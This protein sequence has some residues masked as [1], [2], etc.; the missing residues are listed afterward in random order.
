MDLTKGSLEKIKQKAEERISDWIESC[1]KA[2]ITRLQDQYGQTAF[3]RIEFRKSDVPTP[4]KARIPT[5]LK[6]L[7]LVE[8]EKEQIKG[9]RSPEAREKGTKKADALSVV[10]MKSRQGT[11]SRQTMD[12]RSD[13]FKKYRDSSSKY[14]PTVLREMNN[15]SAHN[16]S[17]F[18]SS[19]CS[20]DAIS[21]LCD[22]P[23]KYFYPARLDAY[24]PNSNEFLQKT[25]VNE[26]YPKAYKLSDRLKF[27][28][29][30]AVERVE[31]NFYNYKNSEKFKPATPKFT[32]KSGKIKKMKMPDGQVHITEEQQTCLEESRDTFCPEIF[33][34]Q[35]IP[36]IHMPRGS[37]K[38]A[39][40]SPSPSFIRI[41]SET[42][43][44]ISRPPSTLSQ[45]P[46]TFTIDARNA[47]RST[48]PLITFG[49][50]ENSRAKSSA[51]NERF[52]EVHSPTMLSVRPSRSEFQ[53]ATSDRIRDS[54]ALSL[55]RQKSK[56][57]RINLTTSPT[58]TTTTLR[59]GKSTTVINS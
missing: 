4:G 6:P 21:L 11:I 22:D 57:S 58:N 20:M 43:V 2:G 23:N 45:I 44:P 40:E 30:N 41:T 18:K 55:K 26:R 49:T 14:S 27:R 16:R 35:E 12:Y 47:R 24:K 56:L 3:K 33:V 54:M 10:S 39:T 1:Q 51:A 59:S 5:K 8:N 9:G 29:I 31:K 28:E 36:R 50:D 15:K 34:D 52:L 37:L 42:P 7:K 38:I 46:P 53:V 25:Y 48:S 19:I 32:R 17:S 13:S